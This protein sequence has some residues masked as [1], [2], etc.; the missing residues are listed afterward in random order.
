LARKE[1]LRRTSHLAH[2]PPFKTTGPKLRPPVRGVTQRPAGEG[3]APYGEPKF[4][5]LIFDRLIDLKPDGTL[6]LNQSIDYCTSLRITSDRFDALFGGPARKPH[7]LL[8][9][10][11]MDL[12]ASIQAVT[13]EIILRL[14]RS[15]AAETG[16]ENL[17]LAG[18]RPPSTAWPTARL[19]VVS[20]ERCS[21]R[22]ASIAG[23]WLDPDALEFSVTQSP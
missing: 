10:R 21:E 19:Q 14:T 7:E 13:E 23:R 22:T 17:C 11:H 18:G 8:N 20:G 9:Q 16:H 4:A 1:R 15:L 12:A 6:R 2:D 5:D 3:L